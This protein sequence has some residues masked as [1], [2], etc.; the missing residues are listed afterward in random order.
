MRSGRAFS[1]RQSPPARMPGCSARRFY[2][3]SPHWSNARI[4]L[5][6]P[7]AQRARD[8]SVKDDAISSTRCANARGEPSADDGVSSP[9][10][11]LRRTMTRS[12]VPALP[13]GMRSR[14]SRDFSR[15]SAISLVRSMPGAGAVHSSKSGDRQSQMR[16]FG[17][18]CLIRV[19]A[20]QLSKSVSGGAELRVRRQT[21]RQPDR[22]GR[23]SGRN[24]EGMRWR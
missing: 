11:S 1:I 24:G 8:R 17:N 20:E 16:L 22:V 3:R 15:T 2:C 21:E 14:P 7:R 13:I 10:W 12:E 19:R 4:R 23:M 5:G 18:V 9:R 6:A